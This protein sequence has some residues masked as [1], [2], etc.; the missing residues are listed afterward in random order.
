MQIVDTVDLVEGWHETTS[1]LVYGFPMEGGFAV[2]NHDRDIT[3]VFTVDETA[4]LSVQTANSMQGL[5]SQVEG[6][7]YSLKEE[8][9][10]DIGE[11]SRK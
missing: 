2:S 11:G 10:Q 3:I 9:G 6:E 4:E 5:Y 7:L 8:T 1:G